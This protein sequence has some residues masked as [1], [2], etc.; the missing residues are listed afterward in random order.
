M[1]ENGWHPLALPPTESA[2]PGWK[3]RTAGWSRL[4]DSGA[5]RGNFAVSRD[6]PHPL[7]AP[8]GGHVF[9]TNPQAGWN[10][11]TER[12]TPEIHTRGGALF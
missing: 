3:R 5:A 1:K 12:L 6:G 4:T 11:G 10:R 9:E 2:R 7:T 8:S